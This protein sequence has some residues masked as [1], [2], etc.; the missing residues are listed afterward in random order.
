MAKKEL[1]VA[2]SKDAWKASKAEAIKFEAELNK[3]IPD[4]EYTLGKFIATEGAIKDSN[5]I[6]F[7]Y[8]LGNGLKLYTKHINSTTMDSFER[9]HTEGV[10]QPRH[11]LIPKNRYQNKLMSEIS[12]LSGKKVRISKDT[13]GIKVKYKEGGYSTKE[14]ART[15]Y[16]N[17]TVDTVYKVEFL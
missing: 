7:H 10:K 15:A 2:A 16:D 5:A 13:D 11:Y 8:D 6:T 9:S 3:P 4:G 17:G 12:E 1:S 14:E